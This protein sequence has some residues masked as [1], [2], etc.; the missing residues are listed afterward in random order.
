MENNGANDGVPGVTQ[1][2][3]MLVTSD[4]RPNPSRG[5]FY[6]SLSSYN[7]WNYLVSQP[8]HITIFEWIGWPTRDLWSH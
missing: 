5:Y 4:V 7:I 3:F 6:I 8:L 1:C 2:N